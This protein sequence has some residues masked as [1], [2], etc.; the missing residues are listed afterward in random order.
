MFRILPRAALAVCLTLA[1]VGCVSAGPPEPSAPNATEADKKLLAEVAAKLLAKLDR[2]PQFDWEQIDIGFM[3]EKSGMNAYSSF[4]VKDKKR[5]P[6][7]RIGLN[8]MAKVVWGKTPSDRAGAADRLAV[9]LGHEFGHLVKDHFTKDIGDKSPPL[10]LAFE[11]GQEIEADRYGLELLLKAGYDLEKALAGIVR[12]KEAL[13]EAGMGYSSFEGLGA[14]HPSWDDRLAKADADKAHL[15]KVMAA[16]ENGVTFLTTEDYDTAITCFEKVTK[17]FPGCYEAW[18]NLGYAYLMKY[19]DQWDK[20]DLKE[21]GIGQ[22]VVGGFYTRVTSIKL[23]GK[24]KK[25]WFNAVGALRES[26]R[27]HPGQTVVLANLGLAYL[28]SPDGKDVG[29]STRFFAEAAAAASK[30]KNIDPVVHAALLINLG[31]NTLAAGDPDKALAQLDESERIVRTL[32]VAANRPVPKFDAPLLFTRAMVLSSKAD[33]EAKQQALQMFEKY[34]KTCSLRSLWW[35]EG[36][37]KYSEVC[38]TLGMEPKSRDA[39]KRD[40][41]EPTKLVTGIKL[42]NG[43]TVTLGEDIEDVEAVLEKLDKGLKSTAVQGTSLIRIRYEK[44]GIELLASD[45]VVAIM[46]F[47]PNAPSIPLEGKGTG[48]GKVGELKIGM[49]TAEVEELL[50]DVYE[51]CEIASTG[52]FYHFYRDQGVAVRKEKGKVVGLVVVKIPQK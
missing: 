43:A 17:Q 6:I 31:V 8:M 48:T 18:A 11:R 45:Y 41:P 34:L 51:P 33:K 13:K 44:L 5:I 1:A 49:A 3:Q 25:F 19:C 28:L 32:A 4:Y 16:F 14:D 23:R 15:W 29:E 20:K 10:T 12:I 21:Q 36:Y 7:I 39:F 40:R 52:V 26:N 38:K 24:D 46:L 2:T 35:D 30:D 42:P 47:G 22:V 50:G 9:I 37:D 27:L